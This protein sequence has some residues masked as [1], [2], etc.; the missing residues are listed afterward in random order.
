MLITVVTIYT[1]TEKVK[2]FFISKKVFSTPTAIK[3]NRK[4]QKS[5]SSLNNFYTGLQITDEH[6]P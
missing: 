2:S 5:V 3:V 6:F 4:L 1:G